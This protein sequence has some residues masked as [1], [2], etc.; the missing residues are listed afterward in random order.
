[1]VG[2]AWVTICTQGLVTF[3]QY[4]F[5]KNYIF[6]DLTE[7]LR[8]QLR[9][10]LPFFMSISFYFFHTYLASITSNMWTFTGASLAVQVIVWSLVIG[11]FYRAYLS[12]NDIKIIA[13]EISMII[14]E[15]F[16]K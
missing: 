11:I 7:F 9:I 1:M 8:F 5:I 3:M 13:R 12:I 2:V 4:R 16:A 15:R 14:R 6:K 10:L